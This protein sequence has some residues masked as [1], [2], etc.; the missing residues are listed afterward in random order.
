MEAVTEVMILA[1]D[2]IASISTVYR[3]VMI[4]IR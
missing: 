3:K 1:Q 2:D 4:T